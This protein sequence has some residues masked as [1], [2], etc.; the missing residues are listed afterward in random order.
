MNADRHA[1]ADRPTPQATIEAL[2]FGLR[3]GLSCLGDKAH[4]GR[5]A[6][7]DAAAVEQ[8]ALRLRSWRC[9]RVAWLPPYADDDI[10]TLLK[11]WSALKEGE[12]HG[13]SVQQVAAGP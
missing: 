13:R 2:M 1:W 3:R 10:A 11:V 6:R 9:K 4:R 12:L 5:L 8:I 7:C